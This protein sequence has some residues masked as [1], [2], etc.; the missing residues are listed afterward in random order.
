M[1]EPPDV[2]GF[3]RELTVSCR[4]VASAAS[5]YATRNGSG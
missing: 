3:R 5:T 4:G 1:P 2:E